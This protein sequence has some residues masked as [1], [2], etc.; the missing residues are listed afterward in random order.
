[1]ATTSTILQAT[2]DEVVSSPASTMTTL[3]QPESGADKQ[4]DTR[5]PTQEATGQE[6]VTSPATATIRITIRRP[7]GGQ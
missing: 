4:T 2:S 5:D 1:T 7:V 6:G 3:G